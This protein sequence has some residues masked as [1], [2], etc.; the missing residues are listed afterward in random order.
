[1]LKIIHGNY[2]PNKVV[3]GT[4]GPV[5]EFSRTTLKKQAK[6]G[7]VVVFLCQGKFCELPTGDP[8]KVIEGLG[9]SE[10]KPKEK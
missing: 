10:L 6:K 4:E 5:E 3:L 9:R 2:Q 7:E 1:M 8:K